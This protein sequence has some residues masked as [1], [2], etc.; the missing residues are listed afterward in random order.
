MVE[1]EEDAGKDPEEAAEKEVLREEI[2]NLS[3]RVAELEGALKRA[4][5]PI[6]DLMGQLDSMRSMAGN[7]FRLLE[8]YHRK[9]TISPEAV[10]PE[11][12]DPIAVEIIKVL[13]DQGDLN[14]SEIADRLRERRGSASRTI[15]R[16]RL[17]Q[18]LDEGV[19]VQE[20]GPH[21]ISLYRISESVTDKWYRLL[22]LRR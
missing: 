17:Q 11:L 21:G 10:L 20:D 15:V 18:L 8:L 1:G 16:Q 9:G 5:Q 7:Y 13:F 2:R 22:G 14:V 6:G 3:E 12:K 19:V 4:T